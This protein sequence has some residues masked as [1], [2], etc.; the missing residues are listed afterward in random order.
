M[1]AAGIRRKSPFYRLRLFQ[2]LAAA[3]ATIS[4]LAVPYICY[5]SIYSQ[6]IRAPAHSGA[7]RGRSLIARAASGESEAWQSAYQAEVERYELLK[8]QLR[9]VGA[10]SEM[11]TEDPTLAASP[12]KDDVDWS[13]NYH[14]LVEANNVLE[15]QLRTY[16]LEKDEAA[17]SARPVRVNV[18]YE[19]ASDGVRPGICSEDIE[20]LPFFGE[21]SAFYTEYAALPLGLQIGKVQKGKLDGAFVVEEV[22]PGGSA[23]RHG[24]IARGDI[25][26]LFR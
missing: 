12:S 9:F 14:R 15:A 16:L 4:V 23:A 13:A 5:L 26:L 3:V 22:L 17:A 20:L 24:V 11:A 25:L 2:F 10:S 8:E 19:P 21:N 1:W 18:A 7:V 6:Q